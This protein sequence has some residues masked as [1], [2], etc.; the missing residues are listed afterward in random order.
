MRAG[1]WIAATLLVAGPSPG[2]SA[3][4]RI[5]LVAAENFY[6]DV[7][8]Q[9]GGDRVAVI[10]ILSN[11]DQDPH[12]FETP[13][14][15][16]REI[17]AAQ[18]VVYNGANYDPWMEKLL[19]VTARPGRVAIRV[20]DGVDRKPGDNPHLWYDPDTMPAFAKT[21]S[22]ALSAIDPA[23]AD[24]YAGRLKG[25]I[26][27]LQPLN[28]KIAAIRGKYGGVSVTATEPLF[29]YMAA[30][31][32]LTMHNERFQLAVMNNTEPS[33]SDLESFQRDLETRNVRVVFFNQQA[34]DNLVRHLVKLARAADISVVGV[35]E[36]CPADQSYQDWMLGEL[37]QTERALARTAS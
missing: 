1:L 13:P 21:L 9:I 8:A 31:L 24:D 12:L 18:I 17:G 34:S 6:G 33:I 28:D 10:S 25:F 2:S 3:D 26:A 4:D 23:H 5:S 15:V 22:E 16:V 27:S 7:A 30:S 36:T 29:G 35:T 19:K 37:Q 14:S 20:A 11:P 32:H